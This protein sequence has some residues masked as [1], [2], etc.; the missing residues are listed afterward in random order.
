MRFASQIVAL[1]WCQH[2]PEGDRFVKLENIDP[3]AAAAVARGEEELLLAQTDPASTKGKKGATAASQRQEI[4]GRLERKRTEQ[5]RATLRKKDVGAKS[6]E[7]FIQT[8]VGRFGTVV[9]AWRQVLDRHEIG[10]LSFVQ[11]CNSVRNMGSARGIDGW[12]YEFYH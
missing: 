8:L 3:A 11:F 10:R 1:I 7:S 12:C 6:K 2:Q 4:L 5:E 9:R